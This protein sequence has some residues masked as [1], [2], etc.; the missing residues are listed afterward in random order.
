MSLDRVTD[1]MVG[2][3]AHP[4]A[5]FKSSSLLAQRERDLVADPELLDKEFVNGLTSVAGK[6]CSTAPAGTIVTRCTPDEKA[7]RRAQRL[8][9]VTRGVYA[10]PDH[11]TNATRLRRDMDEV[12]HARLAKHVYLKYD[13]NTPD[14]L[15]APPPGYLEVSPEELAELGLQQPLLTPDNTSFRAA[16]YKKD[17]M[18]WGADARPIYELA[19]RGS[20]LAK[21]DWVNNMAQNANRESSYYERAVG[22]GNL[23]N[24]AGA[25]AAVHL[26]GHS[27]GGG[28]SM[29]AQGGSGASATTFNSASL[30]P[31]TVARYSILP[32]RQKADTDKIVAYQVE[33]EILS[34]TQETGLASLF[35]RPAIGRRFVIPPSSQA[36]SR[37]DRHG[38]DEA[39]KAIEAQKSADEEAIKNC[40]GNPPK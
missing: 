19:F 31:N 22:I 27:L 4:L 37:N 1:F 6:E 30:H 29:A 12:E 36:L 9:L 25:T 10:C 11:T 32:D 35:T 20:T 28:L 34:L 13:E 33:G 7:A 39:I 24:K 3:I 26:V 21:E 8:D 17:P 38:I 2:L 23:I 5:D 14:E 15:K 18:V 16:V 40:L